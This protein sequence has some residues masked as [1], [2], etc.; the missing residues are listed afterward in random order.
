MVVFCVSGYVVFDAFARSDLCVFGGDGG[1]DGVGN[2]AVAKMASFDS[3]AGGGVGI[4]IY[5]ERARSDGRSV[6]D[7]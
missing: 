3:M 5:F 4:F 6:K 2:L 1:D 7:E